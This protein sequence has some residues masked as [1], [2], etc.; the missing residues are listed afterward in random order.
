MIGGRGTRTACVLAAFALAA[1]APG[2]PP[3]AA[4]LTQAE[5]EGFMRAYEAELRARDR[6]AV[7]ARYDS[8]G[9]YVLGDGGKA[10]LSFDSIAGR[11]RAGWQGPAFFEFRD[12]SY[13]PAGTDAM[14]VAGRFRWLQPGTTDTLLFSYTSLVRRTPAGL[15]IRL[16]NE[17]TGQRG[18]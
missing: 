15:R 1:C 14:V 17:S 16:E 2:A 8:A 9:A 5:V 6:E 12:L 10:F 4:P 13:E 3:A 18:L 7:I 11:Y